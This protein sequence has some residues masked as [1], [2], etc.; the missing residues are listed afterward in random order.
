MST[1]G[2]LWEP[3]EALM[4]RAEFSRVD[5]TIFL[6]IL[7]EPVINDTSKNWNLFSLLVSYSF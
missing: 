5:G 6:S 3:S 2:L 1:L 7:D 4:I